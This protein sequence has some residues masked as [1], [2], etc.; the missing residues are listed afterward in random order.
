MLNTEIDITLFSILNDKLCVVAYKLKT[1]FMRE[2]KVYN[3]VCAAYTTASGRME[4]YD[5]AVKLKKAIVYCDTDY[6]HS[7]YD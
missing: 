2:N 4:L 7:V 6:D 1:P 5:C 3:P